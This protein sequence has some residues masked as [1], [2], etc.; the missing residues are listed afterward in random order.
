MLAGLANARCGGGRACSPDPAGGAGGRRQ[1]GWRTRRRYARDGV[2]Q[3][4]GDLEDGGDAGDE[5]DALGGVG[6]GLRDGVGLL[7]R[8]RRRVPASGLTV[9]SAFLMGCGGGWFHQ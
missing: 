5:D 9:S 1:G 2:K 4:A 7:D 6:D 8:L 3:P